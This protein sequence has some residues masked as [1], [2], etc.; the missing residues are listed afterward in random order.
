[1]VKEE[2]YINLNEKQAFIDMNETVAFSD[3]VMY[4]YKHY[5]EKAMIPDLLGKTVRVSERQ[6]PKIYKMVSSICDLLQMIVPD[7]YVYEDFYYGVESKGSDQ[8]WIEI[9]VKT[10]LDFSAEE[11]TFLLAREL[12]HIHLGHTYYH[13]LIDETLE[14]LSRQGIMGKETVEKTWE[15]VMCKWSRLSHYSA[16]AF[17]YA[18]CGSAPA[19][20]RAIGSLILNSRHLAKELD[21]LQYMK[22]AEEINKLDDTVSILAKMDEQVPYGPLRVKNIVQYASST[23]GL[24]LRKQLHA[25]RK[26]VTI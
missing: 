16:D 20:I 21:L 25:R 23:R 4:Y 11:L 9:S 3:E 6:F 12:C 10:I 14:T 13:T 26:E 2:Q 17:G 5:K 1:M 8:P 15:A 19:A 22:Q 24:E 18:V 7:I